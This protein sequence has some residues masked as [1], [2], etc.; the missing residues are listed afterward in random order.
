MAGA[1]WSEARAW[2]RKETASQKEEE[3]KL[4]P[5]FSCFLFKK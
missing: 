3:I 1:T 5:V 2:W 4:E